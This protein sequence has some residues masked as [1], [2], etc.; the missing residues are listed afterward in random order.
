MLSRLEFGAFLAYSPRGQSAESRRS[1]QLVRAFK[2]NALIARPAVPAADFLA[3]RMSEELHGRPLADLLHSDV[4]LVPVPRSG[5]TGDRP[6]PWPGKAIAEALLA[7]GFGC[8]VACCLRRVRAVTKA[9][10]APQGERPTAAEHRDS[11]AVDSGILF[12]DG[13]VLVDD[14]ITSGAQMLGAAWALLDAYPG[15]P[16]TAFAAV[17]TMSD[18]DVDA[19]LAPVVG[20]ITLDGESTRRRP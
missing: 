16:L 5:V 1:Q 15:L 18:G 6:S 8:R 2:S 9:A 11:L 12:T 17:R 20:Q 19:V 4:T 14:V 10:W 7:R 13:A 3:R